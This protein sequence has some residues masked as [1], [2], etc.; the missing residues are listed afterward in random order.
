M[1]RQ[2]KRKLPKKL[3][4]SE[5]V[6]KKSPVFTPSLSSDTGSSSDCG[7][8]HPHSD[9]ECSYSDA[10]CSTTSSSPVSSFGGESWDHE[11]TSFFT[12]I[13]QEDRLIGRYVIDKCIEQ[14]GF[15][16]V[17]RVTKTKGSDAPKQLAMKV[18]STDSESNVAREI[19]VLRALA[20]KSDCVLSASDLHSFIAPSTHERHYYFTM[21]LFPSDLSSLLNSESSSSS[22]RDNLSDDDSTDSIAS[23][24]NS[25][26]GKSEGTG[27]APA[28]L[29]SELTL[30]A[31][32]LLV[33]KGIRRIL[34]QV[35]DG[36]QAVHEAGFVHADLKPENILVDFTECFV[37]GAE[38]TTPDFTKLKVCLCDLGSAYKMEDKRHDPYGHT[39]CFAAPEVVTN[40]A[41]L[42]GPPVDIFS[43]G[44]LYV[45]LLT[46]QTLFVN[47]RDQ[48]LHLAEVLQMDSTKRVP[49]ELRENREFF[50]RHGQLRHNAARRAS[51]L[52]P[53]HANL[54]MT[55]KQ[56]QFV[57]RC[58][59]VDPAARYTLQ[60]IRS[61]LDTL[62]P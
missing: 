40:D 43:F 14:G 5:Q 59:R 27:A 12:P 34:L 52:G 50:T 57:E 62:H 42:I 17:F 61:V 23:G 58:C 28:R 37:D 55:K 26:S 41:R 2:R 49:V 8:F 18:Y 16:S 35:L 31:D 39:L 30:I 19:E 20:G 44:A 10:R 4:L 45:E 6:P 24:L 9:S 56:R 21:P 13:A 1:P 33:P 60:E 36:L 11:D 32:E 47:M 7:S 3:D 29:R 25:T 22:E 54:S 46:E 48:I 15:A 38:D 51:H 53:W